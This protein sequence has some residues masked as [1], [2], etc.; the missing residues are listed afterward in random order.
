M[1]DILHRYWALF[2][3]GSWPNG[4]LGGFAATL[5]LAGS[6]IMISFPLA[7]GL[8]MARVSPLGLFRWPATVWVYT[9]RGI[10]LIMIIFWAYFVVPVLTGYKVPPFATAP[11][12]FSRIVVSPPALLPGEG[13]L[14]ISA[15]WIFV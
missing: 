12:D 7:I 11:S 14:F 4:P 2:L 8:G 9:F 5:I 10:P 1:L 6:G 3:V 13:L 15:P